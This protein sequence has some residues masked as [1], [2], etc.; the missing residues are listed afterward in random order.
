MFF[1][2][3]QRVSDPASQHQNINLDNVYKLYTFL[4]MIQIDADSQ[5]SNP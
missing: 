4:I 2:T 3:I 1:L 5:T